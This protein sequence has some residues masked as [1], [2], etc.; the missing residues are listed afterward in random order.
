VTVLEVIQRSA[1]FLTRKNVESPRLQ[2]ELL[3]AHVL[4]LPR[5][6]LYLEFDREVPVDMADRMREMVKRR[7]SREPLQHIVGTCVFCGYEL[8]VTRDV[9]VPRPETEILA[10]HGWKILQS[11]AHESAEEVRALDFGTGSGCMAIALA[12]KCPTAQVTAVDASALALELARQ[13][14]ARHSVS[15]RIRFVHADSLESVG[16]LGGFHLII[17]NPPYIPTSE[18]ET[19]E[20]E[21]RDF[22]P[23]QALDG[24]VDGLDFYRL[25][26]RQASALLQP[27]GHLALEFG[28]GQAESISSLLHGENW[29][30]DAVVP[31]Y[32]Q[33]PRILVARRG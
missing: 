33:R 8:A 15:E 26:A 21:V 16:G 4:G 27:N 9:L 31:D 28:D 1:E 12:A 3:L 32:T 6:R 25:L 5:M 7:G 10:E 20:P 17:S 13:N 11:A 19:L 30:V 24:G 18:I 14:A 22:E 23:R 2:S 29:V